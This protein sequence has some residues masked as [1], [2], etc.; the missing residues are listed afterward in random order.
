MIAVGIPTQKLLYF[1]SFG[2][3]SALLTTGIACSAPSM[4]TNPAPAPGSPTENPGADT[5]VSQL[6]PT[7]PPPGRTPGRAA[8]YRVV[9]PAQLSVLDF[10]L[11]WYDRVQDPTTPALAAQEGMN[12]LIPYV[13]DS[14]DATILAYLNAADKAGLKVFL[15]VRRSSVKAGD[16]RAVQAYIRTFKTHPA[17]VGW[18]LFD[19]PELSKNNVSPQQ[20]RQSYLAIKQEDPNRPISVAFIQQRVIPSYLPAVDIPVSFRYPINNGNWEFQG[21]QGGKFI[22]FLD[23]MSQMTAGRRF[24]F[25]LQAFG[26]RN[27]QGQ[28]IFNGRKQLPT[29]TEQ[30]YMVY[31][32]IVRGADGLLFW[33]RYRSV[34]Q[35]ITRTL[36]PVVQEVKAYL[37]S[38]SAGAI[39]GA[40]RVS[41][42]TV[43]AAVFP[44]ATPNRFVLVVVNHGMGTRNVAIDLAGLNLPLTQVR[45]GATAPSPLPSPLPNGTSLNTPAI[46]PSPIASPPPGRTLSISGRRGFT[47]SI[48]SYGVKVYEVN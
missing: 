2:L 6:P 7:A 30:R 43:E 4:S 34:N 32:S 8:P 40:V 42:P 45:Q 41:D 46:T 36:V 33:A 28:I 29:L 10:P 12:L 23:R 18:Y 38:Y 26:D 1:T 11:A 47:E 21:L 20:L 24:W 22:N 5:T 15:E 44:T 13:G 35:W 3:L 27:N 37:P 14:S 16:L 17:V 9:A 19:E 25:A 31:S 39:P 48:G